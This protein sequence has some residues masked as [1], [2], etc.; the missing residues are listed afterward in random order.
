MTEQRVDKYKVE[1]RTANEMGRVMVVKKDVGIIRVFEGDKLIDEAW[2]VV[3]KA[4]NVRLERI[5]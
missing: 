2:L 3:S 1:I 5:K 4:G